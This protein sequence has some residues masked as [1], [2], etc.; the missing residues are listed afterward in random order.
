[1][2]TKLKNNYISCTAYI[3]SILLLAYACVT[4]LNACVHYEKV[5][6]ESYFQS[7][8]FI[9]RIT[10]LG[11][12]IVGYYMEYK[13]FPQKSLDQKVS[14]S[15]IEYR[16]QWY[17]GN[18]KQRLE[19]INFEYKYEIDAAEES[20]N[21]DRLK[22]I[23]DERD[24]KLEEARKENT[25]T[26]EEIK[27]EIAKPKEDEYN[28]HKVSLEELKA[29]QYYAKNKKTGEIYT[30]IQT[31]ST[32]ENY[33]ENIGLYSI[34]L[35]E[36]FPPYNSAYY[37]LNQLLRNYS[38]EVYFIVP[39]ESSNYS[40]IYLNNTRFEYTKQRIINEGFAGIISLV[41]SLILFIISRLAKNKETNCSKGLLSLYTKIPLELRLFIIFITAIP[42]LNMFFEETTRLLEQPPVFYILYILVTFIY[43]LF[44]FENLKGIY[45]LL[46][47][48]EYLKSQWQGT[49]TYKLWL[50]LLR[51]C[52]LISETLIYKNLLLWLSA[53]IILSV[54]F[55]ISLILAV[56]IHDDFLRLIF[57]LYVI[58]YIIL[59][60]RHVLKQ[61]ACLNKIIKGTEEIMYGNL[62]YVI[63]EETKGPLAKLAHNINNIKVG[64]RK[65]LENQMKSERLKSE[66]I[67][68]VSHDLK[69]PLTSIINYVDLLQKEDLSK[70]EIKGYVGVLERKTQRL[71]TL[72]ED[73][74]E[75]SKMAS[76]SV[77]LNTERLDVGALLNQSLA[78]FDEKIKASNLTFKINV[79]KQKIYANLD[80]KKTWRVFENLINNTLKYSMANTRVYIDLT[81]EENRV[82]LIIKNI[83]AY[84]MDFNIDEIFERFK[85]GD[86][87]RHTEGSGLGLAI[88][89]SIV[90]LQGGK[91]NIEIDGDLFKVVVEFYN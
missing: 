27:R 36:E 29:L 49:V 37:E 65:S 85:R 48:R 14:P 18:L 31:V 66:L 67:T 72:I 81:E 40:P 47:D 30:N 54:F 10:G 45:K 84:E 2:A 20:Q 38:L 61:L 4:A 62:N 78:E 35:P 42:Y 3:L 87:S 51:L 90:E 64:L 77:E 46:I 44:V 24:A 74:F 69:T 41:S 82:V 33:M 75:A 21:K 13:D 68:N 57:F 79:P 22:R 83:S 5:T 39:R 32:I 12:N 9:G 86:K 55:C 71:K 76:G 50:L 70:E 17:E 34:N 28:R 23:T 73:L 52:S 6:K 1:L 58:G 53:V 15:E 19:Q 8:D 88:A 11:Y 63:A 56:S 26:I 16:K 25:K 59:I 60:P 43:M 80:G 91:L 89:R 7:G